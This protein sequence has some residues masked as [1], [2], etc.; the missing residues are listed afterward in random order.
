M[1]KLFLFLIS[2]SIICCVPS[3]IRPETIDME[4]DR[5]WRECSFYVVDRECGMLTEDEVRYECSLELQA[6]YISQTSG[7][8]RSWLRSH[9]CPSHVI[10]T[11]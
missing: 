8:Q 7:R 10:G 11:N 1:N 9:G 5:R 4:R 2:F 6:T 3:T